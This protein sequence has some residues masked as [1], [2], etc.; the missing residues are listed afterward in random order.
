MDNIVDIRTRIK[1]RRQGRQIR[2]HQ[3]KIRSLQRVLQC[4]SCHLKCAMC[5]RHISQAADDSGLE[6][7]PL[8]YVFCKSCKGEFEDFLAITGGDKEP[9]V[10]WHNRAWQEMWSAWMDYQ[11]A[12]HRFMHSPEFKLLLS[13]IET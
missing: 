5:G 1:Q 6:P 8:G 2:Q 9:E 7:G 12:I 3:E 11:Q 4:A 13:E 10:F